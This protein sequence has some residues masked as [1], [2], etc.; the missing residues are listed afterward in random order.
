MRGEGYAVRW[1]VGVFWFGGGGLQA[2]P[3]RRRQAGQHLLTMGGGAGRL[4]WG[5]EVMWGAG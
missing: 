5:V 1:G 4:G 3:P 2:R